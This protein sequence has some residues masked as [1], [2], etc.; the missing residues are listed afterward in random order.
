[1]PSDGAIA[2]PTPTPTDADMFNLKGFGD[3]R[4]YALR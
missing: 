3:C 4:H 1:M 2:I